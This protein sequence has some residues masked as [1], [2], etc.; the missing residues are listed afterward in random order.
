[1]GTDGKFLAVFTDRV[2]SFSI[3]ENGLLVS[4]KILMTIGL[5]FTTILIVYIRS[6]IEHT[7]QWVDF[8][9]P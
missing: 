5:F 4:K 9:W 1:L 6:R 2:Y 8:S 7:H 3:G